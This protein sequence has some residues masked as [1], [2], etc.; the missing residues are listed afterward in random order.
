MLRQFT[1]EKHPAKY[2]P[3]IS[4]QVIE[5]FNEFSLGSLLLLLWLWPVIAAVTAVAT[6]FLN[7]THVFVTQML[8]I[9]IRFLPIIII[10]NMPIL[11][12]HIYYLN[13]VVSCGMALIGFV[14][15]N[16]LSVSIHFSVITKSTNLILFNM[17]TLCMQRHT[18]TTRILAVVY[19]AAVKNYSKKNNILN[20]EEKK[21]DS[22]G[23]EKKAWQWI[24]LVV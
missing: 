7:S 11:Q 2:I 10:T 16:M 8:P 21:K 5:P 19:V 18:H 14:L 24:N 15:L 13:R 6:D 22:N 20:G 1:T 3:S 17:C 12:F 23:W 9:I 4:H